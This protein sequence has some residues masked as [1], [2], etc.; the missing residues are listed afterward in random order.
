MISAKSIFLQIDKLK[1][2]FITWEFQ[3]LDEVHN[4]FLNHHKN[5]LIYDYITQSEGLTNGHFLFVANSPLTA[6]AEYQLIYFLA[7][8]LALLDIPKNFVLVN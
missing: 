6:G 7:G 8:Q 2:C 1:N 3:F 4:Y 5:L